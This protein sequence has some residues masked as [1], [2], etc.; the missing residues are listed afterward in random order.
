MEMCS[1]IKEKEMKRFIKEPNDYFE[2]EVLNQFPTEEEW[3]ANSNL[4]DMA[5]DESRG[6]DDE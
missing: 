3:E 5:Y 4:E 2:D 6:E 1:V